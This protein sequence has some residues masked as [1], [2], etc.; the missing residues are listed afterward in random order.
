[1]SIGSK[2]RGGIVV[3]LI[4]AAPSAWAV[5][6]LPPAPLREPPRALPAQAEAQTPAA[7]NTPAPAPDAGAAPDK[8]PP[9]ILPAP[10]MPGANPV[11]KLPPETEEPDSGTAAIPGIPLDKNGEPFSFA[12][13][14]AG[15]LDS[16]V[17][18]STSERVAVSPKLNMPD[19]PGTEPGDK[20]NN[21]G[22]APQEED[23]N[24]APDDQGT[25]GDGGGQP[26]DQ[27]QPPEPSQP[28]GDVQPLPDN[29]DGAQPDESQPNDEGQPDDQGAEGEDGG[30]DQ[31]DLGNEDFFDD[32]FGDQQEGQ[33][34][35]Q[36]V[37]SLGSGFIIDPSGLIVTN[38]HVIAD[39]DE[40]V[41]NLA[42]GEKFKAKVVGIDAK[43]DLALLKIDAPFPLKAA[44]FGRSEKLRVGDWVLAIGNPFGFGGTVTA[45]IVSALDRD[46]NSGPYDH[47]IQ[48]DASINRG[49]SGGPLFNLRGEVVGINTAIMSPTGGSIGIGFSVPSEIA[50]PVIEQIRRFGEVHRGWIGVRIQD[51]TEDVATSLGMQQAT[52]AYIAGMTDDGPA[53][54][55]GIQEGDIVV[56]FNGHKVDS[57]RALPRLVA[58]TPPGD[59]VPVIVMRDGKRL[60]LSIKVGL[61][62]DEQPVKAS[63]K[64]SDEQPAAPAPDAAEA[65]GLSLSALS[66]DLR[67][68]FAIDAKVEGVIVTDVDPGSQADD[69]GLKPGE[70]IVQVSQTDVKEPAEVSKRIDALKAEGRKSV[71]LLVSGAGGKLRFVSLRFD[72]GP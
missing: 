18:I 65:F 42:N 39:A 67:Q 71:M 53:A 11:A 44:K 41:A 19:L 40:I 34:D 17:Y 46:I 51:V 25:D 6:S 57:M 63:T 64:G 4:A 72:D 26:D 66:D 1:M 20:G 43:T 55:A 27:A 58:D 30:N 9:P 12:D 56:E 52:G 16:V 23:Q 5:S 2:L 10:H 32:F 37:Q 38:N 62:K 33:S 50:V 3:A 36:A 45:G 35:E 24:G 29:G 7:P 60:T 31:G 14:A 15:L 59:N 70:V 21:P 54:T 13:L 8:L 69:K 49:N 22:M 28:D 68:Q 48:T 61:L 47:Y